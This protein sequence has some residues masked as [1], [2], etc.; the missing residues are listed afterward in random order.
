MGQGVWG[1]IISSGTAASILGIGAL[2]PERALSVARPADPKLFRLGG[3]VSEVEG[4]ELVLLAS[5]AERQYDLAVV[6]L[7]HLRELGDRDR[8]LVALLGLG[9]LD[10]RHDLLRFALAVI[11]V[12]HL[13][14][15]QRVDHELD[16]HAEDVDQRDEDRCDQR[17]LA[18]EGDGVGRL[19][20]VVHRLGQ[21]H[22]EIDELLNLGEKVHVR[23]WRVR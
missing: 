5:L 17:D 20:E 7:G 13:A 8:F 1:G 16:R 14:P 10:D 23:P 4:S 2:V 15:A 6:V 9:D 3:S 19:P 12:A 22:Q 18:V 11:D 21:M